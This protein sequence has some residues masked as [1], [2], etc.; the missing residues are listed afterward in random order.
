MKYM[1]TQGRMHAVG[2]RAVGTKRDD[3]LAAEW[4]ELMNR[5]HRIT[6]ALDR[7][8]LARHE[9]TISEFEVLQQ[10]AHA[11]HMALRMNDLGDNAH[12]S[13]S[14]LSRLIGRLEK[15]GLVVREM[16]VDDRRSV[17]TRLTAAGVAR[18]REAKPTHREIL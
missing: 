16:C 12:L 10:L 8:L 15:D 6:C 14:A 1:Y 7:E 2:S 5:F 18:Y 13:Q 17:W 4:H 11:D 9:L 3:E